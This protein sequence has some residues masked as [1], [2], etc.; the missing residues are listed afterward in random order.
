MDEGYYEAE[1]LE[2]YD[3]ADVKALFKQAG[4]RPI[5]PLPDLPRGL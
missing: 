3:F 1:V 5:V 2:Q 4:L